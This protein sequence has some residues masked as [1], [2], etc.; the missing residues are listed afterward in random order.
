MAE[1]SLVA[2]R[3]CRHHPGRAAAVA[4]VLALAG[5]VAAAPAGATAHGGV[6]RAQVHPALAVGGYPTGISIDPATA[7]LYV[8]DESH[9]D[10]AV[11]DAASCDSSSTS[12]CRAHPR[13]ASAGANPVG[14]AVDA[15]TSTLYVA[16]EASD[17]VVVVGTATCDRID[18]SRCHAARASVKVG[19]G[20]EYLAVDVA[21][22]TVYVANLGSNSVS[23]ISGLRCDASHTAGCEHSVVATI[24]T[25]PEP[26]AIA[27]DSVTDT[28]YV[29]DDDADTV[30]VIDGATCNA[31][32]TS[33]C[34]RRPH[35]LTVGRDPAGIAI[36]AST[37]T[38]YVSS[39]QS[40]EISVINTATC[41]AAVTSGCDQVAHEARGGSG[42][43]G[44]AVDT[45]TDTVYVADSTASSLAVIDGA[46][47][48]STSHARC[49]AAPW[50]ARVAASP[51]NVVVDPAT[52][53]IYVTAADADAVTMVDGRT[54]DATAHAGC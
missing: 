3:A 21:T 41:D 35:H 4:C 27:I 22:D 16:N 7:T 36:D 54:C 28:V 1:R 11:L 23:V 52:N 39:Q 18:T 2:R 49:G 32:V 14:S 45:A 42:P 48:D 25:G 24:E 15:A 34:T 43:R 17:D 46:T 51:R 30:S 29:T 44:I 13:T 6:A 33:G 38:L 9:L 50:L 26:F 20:P 8:G 31:T 12:G 10:L 47:C 19:I 40:D 53:S 5:S 37:N